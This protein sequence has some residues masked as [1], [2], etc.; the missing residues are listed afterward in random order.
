[1]ATK[2]QQI[3]DK[4]H[5]KS[6]ILLDSKIS[7]E[8]PTSFH[9]LPGAKII[10]KNSSLGN[11]ASYCAK[12]EIQLVTVPEIKYNYKSINIDRKQQI[13]KYYSRILNCGT[14][15]IKKDITLIEMVKGEFGGVYYHNMQRCGSVWFCPDCM[16]KLM[17]ARAEELYKQL[18]IYKNRNQVIL[19]ITFT[20]QHNINSKLSNLLDILH[21]AFKHA[22]THRDWQT[23]K[24]TIPI[25][26]LRVLEILFGVN[27][28]HNHYHT[29]FVGGED[30]MKAINVFITLYKQYLQNKGL[31]INEHTVVVER[32][33]GKL[34]DMKDY[35]FKGM[36]EQELTGGGL[37]KHNKGKT[38]FE[39]IDN[40]DKYDKQIKEYVNVMKGKRQYHHS[41]G[42]FTIRVKTDT[43]ILKEDKAI[44]T[45]YKIPILIY[46][47]IFKKGIALYLLN[48]YNFKGTPGVIK[49]LELYDCDTSF[50][51]SG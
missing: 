29:V 30:I 6:H 4:K 21:S 2:I 43:E 20:L 8:I 27:G 46:K 51:E 42:F 48:E 50:I 25:E 11:I 26:Y 19:F 35:M 23:I 31:L 49:L 36:L 13:G 15:P 44:E 47:D 5:D 22:N 41:K 17:K 3:V 1:V 16:Y 40:A 7:N 14:K 32:W 10:E 34:E 24:K 33:N 39:L 9:Q 38:F 28:W 18:M 45:I 37:K 12:T